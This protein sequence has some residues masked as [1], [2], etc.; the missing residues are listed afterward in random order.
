MYQRVIDKTARINNGFQLSIL[1]SHLFFPKFVKLLHREQAIQD[2]IYAEWE[3]RNFSTPSKL[4]IEREQR[5][6]NLVSDYSNCDL[7]T[8]HIGYSDNDVF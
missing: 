7:L 8:V 2:V 4:S 5:L 3:G 6:H 1:C